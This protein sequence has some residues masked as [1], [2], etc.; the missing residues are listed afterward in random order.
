MV[1]VFNELW[2]RSPY[3]EVIGRV[4]AEKGVPLVD[5]SALLARERQRIEAERE[6][7]LGLVVPGV[8]R[9]GWVGEGGAGGV[10][11][12]DS[13]VTVLFRVFAGELAVPSALYVAGAGPELGN[14]VP[15]T[16]A[17]HDDGAAGDQ[18]AGDR[19]WSLAVPLRLGAKVAYVYT[20]SG[21]QGEWEGLDVPMVRQFTIE[22][23]GEAGA[24]ADSLAKGGSAKGWGRQLVRPIETFGAVTLQADPWHPSAAGYELIAGEVMQALRATPAVA[25]RLGSG[26]GAL[27]AQGRRP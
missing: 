6:R 14:V 2:E 25:A 3:R 11:A 7:E 19:V 15:N 10:D 17:L 26:Q 24:G 27:G 21:R 13:T 20:N 9:W 23:R 16:L 22:A 5:S 12:A 8:D 18:K 4:A 1:L